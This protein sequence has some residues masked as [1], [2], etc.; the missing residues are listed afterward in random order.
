MIRSSIPKVPEI[1]SLNVFTISL[2]EV[3]DE[4]DFLDS[5]KHP[6]FPQVG[7]NPL[8]IK[9][10]YKAIGMIMRNLKGMMIGTIKHSQSTQSNKFAIS[11][12]Y[13]SK[14][15]MNG[16]HFE[17]HQDQNFYKLDYG[18]LMKHPHIKA[19]RY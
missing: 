12:Q 9:V 2:K 8:G 4:V 19:N 10:F 13:L 15:V 7:F 16:V 14:E 5:D 6:S 18:F 1:A 17:A 11:L 3:R